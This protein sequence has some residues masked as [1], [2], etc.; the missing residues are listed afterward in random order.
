MFY[1]SLTFFYEDPDNICGVET[2][3]EGVFTNTIVVQQHPVIQ[4]VN[5]LHCKTVYVKW[6]GYMGFLE[7]WHAA[8]HMISKKDIKKFPHHFQHIAGF[9]VCQGS[10]SPLLPI[11]WRRVPNLC[12]ATLLKNINIF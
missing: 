12:F 1:F 10:Q 6:F 2:E 8:Q 4:Q 5:M 7:A 9:S 11:S 3:G